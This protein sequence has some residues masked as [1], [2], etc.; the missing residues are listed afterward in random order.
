M[1]VT[2]PSDA[3]PDSLGFQAPAGFP[4]LHQA[5]F[6]AD[7]PVAGSQ[8]LARPIV[9]GNGWTVQQHR[10]PARYV[11]SASRAAL[12]DEVRAALT[13]IRRY[14]EEKYPPSLPRIV[15]YDTEAEEPFVLYERMA[16]QP[17]AGMVGQFNIKNRRLLSQGLISAL[18]LLDGAG[19][20]HRAVTPQNV[21]WDGKCVRLC[22]LTFA[23]PA[24][25]PRTAVGDAP[26]A[27]PEQLAAAGLTDPR[28]DVWSAAQVLYHVATGKAVNPAGPPKLLSADS[29]LSAQLAGT[30]SAHA[31]QRP[32]S[33]KLLT[34]LNRR[35]PLL[36][37]PAPPDP[38]APG[39]RDFDSLALRKTFDDEPAA[40]LV[41]PVRRH[42][43]RRAP[44][45]QPHLAQVTE[46]KP[47]G[48]R[49]PYCLD[50]LHF[51]PGQL[52]TRDS[53]MQITPVDLSSDSNALRNADAMR[54]LFQACTNTHD[55]PPH[56][57]PA[58]YLMHG[59]PLTIALAGAS[60]AGKTNL[61]VSMMSEIDARALEP[62]GI[63]VRS[64]H[65]EWHNTFMHRRVNPL[66]SGEVLPATPETSF[67]EFEDALL[68]TRGG[69]TRP[70]AFFDVSG[71]N[72][73]RSDTTLRFMAGVDALIFVVD[74]IRALKLPQAQSERTRLGLGE[75]LAADPTFGTVLDRVPN[76]DGRIELPTA[77]AITKCDLLR[78]E[79]PVDRWLRTRP[80]G[81]GGPASRSAR[82]AE[83]RD[84][85][86]FLSLYAARP[87][88]RPALECA[89][90]T[91]HFVSA[92]GG[93]VR[94]GQAVRGLHPSRVLEPLL[95]VLEMCG[96]LG[97]PYNTPES[98]A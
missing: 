46:S 21:L 29:V 28:D 22:S 19:L 97:D 20:V 72:L 16:G 24:G 2:R 47:F 84:A 63:S 67:A 58:E 68:F 65:A 32:E 81:A 77:V 79:P 17:L 94:E 50:A 70:V 45:V 11:D 93:P 38:L 61:L 25:S 83:S 43:F 34:R 87:W 4:V 12:E 44:R 92:I 26:W 42:L 7:N 39:R 55:L 53:K 41:R 75:A 30:F 57:L 14:G 18:R 52:Y 90:C 95:S 82:T 69:V 48:I 9:L 91:L 23:V 37:A 15:G 35:D 73:Y 59:R 10:L 71:E 86:A 64:A 49:C 31:A 66:R 6:G 62:Y 27:S 98:A 80:D 3:G 74:P 5:V 13:L 8:Q 56:Y 54:T 1:T 51:D 36:D 76:R 85:Y 60:Q 88:L 89:N 96:V 40:E 78:F 33:V